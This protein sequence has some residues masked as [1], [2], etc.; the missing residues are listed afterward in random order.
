[1]FLYYPLH[2]TPTCA[3][4]A[5]HGFCKAQPLSKL[6]GR[7]RTSE[8][9]VHVHASTLVEVCL[10]C[11]GVPGGYPPPPPLPPRMTSDSNELS[12]ASISHLQ[13][14]LSLETHPLDK[15]VK[16][17]VSGTPPATRVHDATARNEQG[18]SGSVIYV[19]DSEDDDEQAHGA[20]PTIDLLPEVVRPCAVRD[21]WNE[22]DIRR[23]LDLALRTGPDMFRS[24]RGSADAL[25]D[26]PGYY[27]VDGTR[28]VTPEVQ[29]AHPK[30]G[31]SRY[32]GYSVVY[33]LGI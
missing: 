2:T 10:L 19:S 4:S 30:V 9:R 20:P 16:S 29:Q 13:G 17:S 18:L 1:M 32:T 14:G 11:C 33:G 26:A 7:R 22:V 25:S 24:T 31:A 15:E 28:G 3:P 8:T 23:F 21:G 27:G 12:G 5:H 6:W